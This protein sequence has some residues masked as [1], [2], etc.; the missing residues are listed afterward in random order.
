MGLFNSIRLGSSAA[1]DYEIERSLRFNDDDNAHLSRTPS[2]SGNRKTWT[3]SA[4]VKRGNLA[5]NT[6]IMF[7]AYD[8]SASRRFQF[9][10]NTDDKLLY[11]QG[12]GGSGSSG[13]ATS[14]M[15]FRDVSAWYHL[16]FRADYTNGTAGDRL[17]VY[18]NGSQIDMTFSDAVTDTDGQWNKTSQEHEIGVLGNTTEPFDGYMADIYFVDGTALTPS[19]FGK[20]DPLTGQWIP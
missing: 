1:G 2:G 4:W 7:H 14:D 17:K 19:S 15:L 18:V 10:F 12:G 9:A 11:N 16:V 20:T 5:G 13:V 3:I 6:Q 8:G